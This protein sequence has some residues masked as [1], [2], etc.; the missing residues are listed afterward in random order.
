MP[1]KT[2]VVPIDGAQVIDLDARK[3]ARLEKTG[4]KKVRFGG[5]EWEFK[6]ELP[7]Q[8]VE[9]FT[10]GNVVGAF[11]RILTRSED[12]SQFLDSGDLSQNDFAE[13]M[14]AVY[15]LDLPAASPSTGS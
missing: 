10:A 2:N 15:G 13:L 11:Q 4:P 1:A 8:V 14:S 9:D 6:P 3:A 7:L 5:K 12:A